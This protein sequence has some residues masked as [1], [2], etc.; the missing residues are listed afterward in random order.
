[1]YPEHEKLQKVKD[2]SQ[3]IGAFLEWLNEREMHLCK[4]YKERGGLFINSKTGK[5][6]HM[7]DNNAIDNPDHLSE[8]YYPEMVTIENLLSE[9]FEIDLNI[10]E[11]EKRQMLDNLRKEEK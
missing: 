4:Y 8:G 6:T 3:T 5:P 11:Q 2:Q 10:L 9:Y 1:M 7:F